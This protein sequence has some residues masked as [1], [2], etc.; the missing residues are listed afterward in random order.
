[1][2]AARSI[3][4]FA[5]LLLPNAALAAEADPI[6]TLTALTLESSDGT[7]QSLSIS[8]QVLLAMTALTVLPSML[9]ML[10]AFTRIVVVFAILRQALGLQQTPS[11]QVLVGLALF[12]SI[13]I[14][15]PVFEQI[16]EIALQPYLDD[17]LEMREAVTEASQP[18]REFMLRQMR[19]TDLDMFMSIAAHEAVTDPKDVDFFVMVP[20]FMTSELKTAFQMGFMLFIPF[21]VIDMVVASVLMSMGMMMLS[22]LIVSLPFKLMLF[23]LVDGWV[24][25]MGALTTSFAP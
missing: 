9:I 16:N 22:P 20:A 8:I 1:M 18:V 7:Q 2:R 17:Q 14:M 12:L 10:T 21:L 6:G 13:F 4:W 3:L 15:L 5:A 25:V 24:L 19:D 11:N 23:V